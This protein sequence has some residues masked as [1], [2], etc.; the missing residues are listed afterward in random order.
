MLY[1]SIVSTGLSL[2]PITDQSFAPERT[3]FHENLLESMTPSPLLRSFELFLEFKPGLNGWI[4]C[5]QGY[6]VR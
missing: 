3:T 6:E 4:V 2:E 5:F 1:L